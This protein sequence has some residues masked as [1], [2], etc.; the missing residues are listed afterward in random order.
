MPSIEQYYEDYWENPDEYR[1]PTTP[2]RM[3]LLDRV[4]PTLPPNARILDAGCGR[5]E[6]CDYFASKGL[7]SEGIDISKN[8]I[9]F[10]AKKYPKAKFY[11]GMIES[12][13]EENRASYD[14]V[15]TSEVIEH[16]FDV[17][18][19]LLAINHLLKP[20]GTLIVTTPYHGLIKNFVV[21]LTNY[22]MHYDP[23]GQHIRFFDKKSLNRCLTLHAF[24]PEHWWGY[25]RPWPLY[26]SFFVVA[27]KTGEAQKLSAG[28]QGRIQD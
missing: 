21:D 9:E 4:L 11:A 28:T 20:G 2:Q 22:A 12:L 16:L 7:R 1:D 25:G 19:Y 3:A 8:V 13:V 23:L 14:A 18:D 5:G 17:G 24:S 6:F 10:A 15:F 27:K 26:K